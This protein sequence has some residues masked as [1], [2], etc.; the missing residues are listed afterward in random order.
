MRRNEIAILMAAGLGTRMAPLTNN[1]PKP[2]VKV[3]GKP[4][5]KTV[6]DGLQKRG[7]KHIYV[8]VGYK[9]EQFYELEQEYSNLTIIENEEYLTVNNIS[10]IK[11]ATPVM[12][13]EDCFICEADLF[14][15]DDSIFM[16]DLNHSCYYGKMK[17]GFSD[18]WVFE[19]DETGRIIRVGKCGTDCYNMCGIAWF[20][21]DD[22]K[23]I[24]DAII[25]AYRYPGKY[26]RLFWDDIVNQE[27]DNID[28]C[29]HEV[30]PNQIVELDSVKE[31]EAID[32][33][34]KEYN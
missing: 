6:I 27:I 23:R 5:I 18:D 25:E 2:L 20:K 17:K 12:G 7:I 33:N 22:A 15:S 34:Y 19:Q 1:T 28:L 26:E 10:S 8:V 3:F 9:K 30:F 16:A 32:P 21:K 11:A 29:V 4:M 31:L 24:A 13:Q 14:V